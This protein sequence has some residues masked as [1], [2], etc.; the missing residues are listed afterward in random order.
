M[1]CDVGNPGPGLEQAEKYDWAKP[2]NVF[3]I[4]PMYMESKTANIV[5]NNRLIN[6]SV[7]HRGKYGQ[8]VMPSIDSINWDVLKE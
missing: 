7:F 6:L 5:T 8:I 3:P 2:I 1:T 4:L